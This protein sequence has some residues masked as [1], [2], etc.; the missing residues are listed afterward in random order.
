MQA[1]A[2]FPFSIPNR[3]EPSA[4]SQGHEAYVT[5]HDAFSI[6]NRIEPSATLRSGHHLHPESGSFS[7]PNRIEPSATPQ[8]DRAAELQEKLSVSPIGS[9]PLQRGGP[10]QYEGWHK[11]LSVSPI[12]SSPLQL[13]ALEKPRPPQTLSVSPIGSS[14]LQLLRR[15]AT[16]ARPPLL[17]VSPIGSSPLQQWRDF[18][19]K[20]A[21]RL[22]QYPQSDRALCNRV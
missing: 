12:G 1:L 16:S 4:T 8:V 19:I 11:P 2:N 18:L 5:F 21:A 6:P 22:F 9:S 13:P 3:I 15:Q 20:E 17:S 7:I 10:L 14:P